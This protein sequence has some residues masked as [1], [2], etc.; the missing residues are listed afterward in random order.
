[1]FETGQLGF[2]REW[3]ASARRLLARHWF[4]TSL[5]LACSVFAWGSLR[6]RA[7]LDEFTYHLSDLADS[8][9]GVLFVMSPA[10]CISLRETAYRTAALLVDRGI[11][12]KALIVRDHVDPEVLSALLQDLGDEFP[13]APVAARGVAAFLGRIGTPVAMVVGSQGDIES[14][15]LLSAVD[16]AALPQLL[17]R[18]SDSVRALADS[19]S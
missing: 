17:A 7:G 14:M 10:E 2:N 9:G 11:G 4:P 16:P 1:M 15:E 12:V 3:L 19:S 6:T 8:G 18:L 5:V 13:H